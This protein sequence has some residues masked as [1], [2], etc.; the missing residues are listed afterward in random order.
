M[1]VVFTNNV[2]C[3][4]NVYKIYGIKITTNTMIRPV[5]RAPI[6]F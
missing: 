6:Q 5:S 1:Y 4:L 2:S 3:P